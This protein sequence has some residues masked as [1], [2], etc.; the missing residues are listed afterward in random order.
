MENE[1]KAVRRQLLIVDDH[2]IVLRGMVSVMCRHGYDA[3][4]ARG[5]EEALK[6]L[7]RHGDFDVAVVDLSLREGCDGLELVRELREAGM[8]A[9]VV[10]YTMHEELWSISSLIEADVEGIVLKGDDI[11]ELI[12]AVDIVAGGGRYYSESFNRRRVEVLHT[13]GVLSERAIEVL[14]RAAK[15]ESTRDIALALDLNEKTV[16]YHRSKILEKLGASS[17]AEATRTALQLGIIY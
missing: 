5:R 16:E 11:R 6:A 2:Q 4:G 17:I 3:I 9:P 12:S 15:G 8:T 13:R 10:V 1:T 7:R 14:Q